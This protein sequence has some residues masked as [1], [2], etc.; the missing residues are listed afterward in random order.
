MGTVPP[1]STGSTPKCTSG[2]RLINAAVGKDSWLLFAKVNGQIGGMIGAFQS[3]NSDRAMIVSVYVA[4]DY[5]GNGVAS[6][7]M[8]AILNELM[9]RQHIR[10]L[11]LTV[12]RG[13]EAAIRLYQN[14]GFDVIG[15]EEEQMGDGCVHIGYVM[16]R[17]NGENNE[18]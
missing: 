5:R 15:K 10:V 8:K 18:N 16:E 13:Q 12:T 1:D 14:F 11:E 4:P 6:A 17:R 7:L 3:N 9:Q 2:I